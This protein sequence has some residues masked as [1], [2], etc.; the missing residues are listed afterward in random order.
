LLPY[1]EGRKFV[2]KFY[3]PGFG[4]AQDAKYDVTGSE[5]LLGSDGSRID[6]WVM[7]HNFE[8]PSGGNGTQRFWISKRTHEILKE[9]DKTPDGYRYKLKIA[10]SGER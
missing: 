2:I 4:K 9:E 3:D 10:I 8:I 6:C 7:Q 5:S 1:K